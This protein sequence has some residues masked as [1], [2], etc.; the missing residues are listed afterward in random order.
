[1]LASDTRWVQ[2]NPRVARIQLP[3]IILVALGLVVVLAVALVVQAVTGSAV[4]AW[5]SLVLVL[6][7]TVARLAFW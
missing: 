5:V 2:S 3:R 7:I 4:A 6:A 1:M